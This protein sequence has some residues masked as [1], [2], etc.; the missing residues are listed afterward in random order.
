MRLC[1]DYRELNKVTLKNKYALPHTKYLFDQ[2]RGAGYFSKID[3][4]LAIIN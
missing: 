2:L 1:I 4:L 3:L